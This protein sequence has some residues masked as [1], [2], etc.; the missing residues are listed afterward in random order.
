MRL[1][2]IFFLSLFL[3]AFITAHAQKVGLVLSGGGASGIAHIGVIKALEHDSIPIDYITGTSMGALVGALYAMGYSPEQMEQI[4]TSEQFRNWAYGRIDERYI[5]YFKRKDDD[6]SWITL[7]LALDSAIETSLPTNLVSP[8]PLDFSLMEITAPFIASAHYKFD[9]LFVPYRCLASD[10]EAKKN[11]VFREGDL[12]LAVR[13]SM[14]Y[15][16]YLKPVSVD[17]KLLYDG[18]IYNNFPANVMYDD[19]YP[20]IIVG[21][22]VSGNDPS[23]DEDNLISQ[24]KTML[25]TKTNFDPV[26][27]NGVIIEP[28]VND[29]PT[30]NFDNVKRLIDSGYVAA[31][32]KITLLK[33]CILRRVAPNELAKQREAFHKKQFP[34]IFENIYVEGLKKN[35]VKYVQHQLGH[36]SKQVS[37]QKLK[38]DYFRLASDDKI[39]SIFPTATFN[40]KSGFYDLHLKVKKEKDLITQFGGNFSNRPISEGFIGLQYNYLNTFASSIYANAYFGKLYASGQVKIRVDLPFHLPFYFEPVY[41]VNK[42]DFFKS[43]AQ[44]ITDVKPPFLVQY[45]QYLVGNLGFP[46]GNKGKLVGGAGYAWLT[47]RYYQTTQFTQKDTSDKTDFNFYLVHASFEMNSLNRKQYASQG[48]YF[49]AKAAYITGEELFVPGTTS[50]V[51]TD[52]FSMMHHWVQFKLTYD[53][54]FKSRR[55][56]KTGLFFE[57]VYSTQQFF[58]NYTSSV[59]SAP[60]FQPLPESKTLFQEK[61]RA[62]KYLAAGIKQVFSIRKIC[63]IRF[64]GYIY[65]PY[66]QIVRGPGLVAEYTKPFLTYYFIGTGAIVLHTPLGPAAVS[67]NYYYGEKEPFTF[68]FHFGYIIFNKKA[69]D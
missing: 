64:E 9:S 16:F 40:N 69:L 8:V 57:G 63:D 5:Y 43:S 65:Q 33:Q 11:V 44:F 31:Q 4:V 46:V 22:N 50:L 6:A 66:Q 10:I 56:F 58:H 36:R 41:T 42:W 1:Q 12:G 35:Q 54:Y 39:K 38:P 21:S 52:T 34:L 28:N 14:S 68:L 60:A 51:R 49:C 62:H 23:P 17:G 19:F 13:A 55:F 7:K 37:I 61:F 15:P 67:V 45:E 2:R 47:D 53:K 48:R 25:L 32:P 18:G 24:L 29:A 26:C 27:Q 3:F 59:L 20:D 30:F